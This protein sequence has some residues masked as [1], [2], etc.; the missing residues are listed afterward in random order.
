MLVAFFK[1]DGRIVH[2]I[3]PSIRDEN[4]NNYC[5]II[6]SLQKFVACV[7]YK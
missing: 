3:L 1:E 6:A 2:T 7:Q 4:R 5:N